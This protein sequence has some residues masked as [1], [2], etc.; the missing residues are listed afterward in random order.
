VDEARGSPIDQPSHVKE[1]KETAK[2]IHHSVNDS[3]LEP[4][5]S[6][7]SHVVP[8]I[9]MSGLDC[10]DIVQELAERRDRNH[11]LPLRERHITLNV[12]PST[13]SRG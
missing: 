9:K 12:K 8:D 6:H 7:K 11:V 1:I 3:A 5:L 13:E 2:R 4:S 10:R